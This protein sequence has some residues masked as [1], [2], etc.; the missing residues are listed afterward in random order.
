MEEQV[1]LVNQYRDSEVVCTR[2][3]KLS[4]KAVVSWI[5]EDEEE[6]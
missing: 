4:R 5:R 6:K 3:A 2:P 1:R